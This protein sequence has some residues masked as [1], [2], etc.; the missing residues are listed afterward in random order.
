MKLC[1]YGCEQKAKYYFKSTDKWCCS[2]FSAQCPY[3]RKKNSTALKK[4][5]KQGKRKNIFPDQPYVNG[6]RKCTISLRKNLQKK[7]SRLL[8]EEKPFAERKRILLKEQ[9][10][11][12]AICGIPNI[13]NGQSLNFHY[14]HINGN[15]KDNR[16]KN[17]RLVCP[18]CHT[19]TKT[20]CRGQVK[21]LDEY[22]LKEC[23][24]KNDL[25]INKSLVELGFVAGGSNWNKAKTTIKKYN[26][27]GIDELVQSLVLGTRSLRRPG[28]TPGS[29]TT[30]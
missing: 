27:G 20:Y 17:S 5:Y 15:R 22:E 28:S 1:D 13:W 7:Y 21:I 19:Q 6:T 9:D 30:S 10:N 23:L 4:A 2:K 24:I 11:L 26:L 14:D 25:N 29:P 16:R 3:I 8:F 18:N 12:C